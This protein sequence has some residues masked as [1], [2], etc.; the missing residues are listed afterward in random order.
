MEGNF[1]ENIK[2][3]IEHY[4]YAVHGGIGGLLRVLTGEEK[5]L[6]RGLV[7]MIVGST[8]AHYITPMLENLTKRFLDLDFAGYGMSF[9][10]GYT[11]LIVLRRLE[12]F[13]KTTSFI[14]FFK[15]DK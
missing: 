1:I 15:K 11:G 13:I 4:Q 5:S 9:V 14:K 10:V 7:T 3:V 8:S 2:S 12:D 6:R